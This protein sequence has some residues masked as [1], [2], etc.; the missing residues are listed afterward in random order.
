MKATS[1]MEV[2]TIC[3]TCGG[4]ARQRDGLGQRRLTVLVLRHAVEQGAAVGGHSRHVHGQAG[5]LLRLRQRR[6]GVEAG[7]LRQLA[8]PRRL[9]DLLRTLGDQHAQARVSGSAVA[10][11]P[12]STRRRPS[13]PRLS[14][15][16]R[17]P[18]TP[19]GGRNG[20]PRPG[21]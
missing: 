18:L 5:V 14:Q 6:L 9:L 8:G 13:L 12:R 4:G 15:G 1:E 21:A 7:R 10:S 3:P 20:Y 2:A 11:Q 16:Q 19:N 17:G